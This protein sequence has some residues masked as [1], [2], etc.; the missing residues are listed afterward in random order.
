[1]DAGWRQSTRDGKG[2]YLT[3]VPE[4]VPEG[5]LKAFGEGL[6]DICNQMA[7]DLADSVWEQLGKSDPNF[8]IVEIRTP[9]FLHSSFRS[10][11]KYQDRKCLK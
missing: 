7:P 8:V 4:R 3:F 5:G 10:T 6:L 1:M 11:F 2:V 9:G